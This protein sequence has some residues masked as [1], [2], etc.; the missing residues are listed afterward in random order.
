MGK[1]L[2]LFAFMIMIYLI[3]IAIGCS[4]GS[5]AEPPPSP[6]PLEIMADSEGDGVL[7]AWNP[8]S[9]IDAFHIVTPDG[10]TATLDNEEIFYN[11]NTPASTGIYTVFAV[12]GSVNG[13]TSQISSAPYAC[14]SEN[15]LT[16]WPSEYSGFMFDTT[17]GVGINPPPDP[18]NADFFLYKMQTQLYF[19]SADEDPFQG[20]KTT[21]IVRT[22]D[23]DFFEAPASEYFNSEVVTACNYYAFS[24]MS[25]Y[26]AKVHVVSAT[27]STA[28]FY[29]WFQTIQSL[30]IF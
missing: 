3:A 6:G 24:L 7:I 14:P 12:R 25:D 22:G 16:A 4:K 29:Y 15:T 8:V 5:E 20:S 11:D 1:Y 19:I 28:T 18:S 27:D 2:R 10:D 21:H 26:Y 13:D 30:R 9:N 23:Q 17:D